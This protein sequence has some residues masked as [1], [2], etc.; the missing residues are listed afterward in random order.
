[1]KAEG[2]SLVVPAENEAASGF[3]RAGVIGY[4]AQI[5]HPVNRCL[6]VVDPEVD[7]HVSVLVSVV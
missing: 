7:D 2:E 5:P 4:A 1:M 3:R 6:D